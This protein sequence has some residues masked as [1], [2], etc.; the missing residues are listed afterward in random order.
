MIFA[1]QI[2]PEAYHDD[3]E[4]P[5]ASVFL[6]DLRGHHRHL[7]TGRLNRYT[8]AEPSEAHEGAGADSFRFASVDPHR[9][10]DV[11]IQTAHAESSGHHSNDDRGTALG[12]NRFADNRGVRPESPLPVS[13]AQNHFPC[14]AFAYFGAA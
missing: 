4:T 6:R 8:S 7:G 12:G 13:I 9:S 10:I 11:N 14:L 1:H 2:V 3:T 5:F